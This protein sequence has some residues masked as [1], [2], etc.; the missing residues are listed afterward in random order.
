M[1]EFVVRAQGLATINLTTK[2]EV[3]STYYEDMKGAE[4]EFNVPFRHKY[5]YIRR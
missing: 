3:F 5:G 4:S 2:F 1:G